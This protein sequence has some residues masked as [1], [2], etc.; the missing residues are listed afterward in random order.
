[1]DFELTDRCK[2]FRERL[3]AFMDDH[4][5]PAEHVYDEQIAA[6]GNPHYHPP[7]MEELKTRAREL[8]LWN[9]FHPYEEWG[10]A[11]KNAEYAPLAEVVAAVGQLE[12]HLFNS[13]VFRG[14]S[15]TVESASARA[16]PA[17]RCRT[18][19]HI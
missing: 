10:P 3:L 17:K 6:S 12:V 19:A 8:G 4:V 7:V 15:P 13:L 14:R 16:I 11:L 18:P 2:D 5:Y 1:M 9:L